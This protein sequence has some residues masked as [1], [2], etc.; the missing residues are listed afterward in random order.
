LHD[1]HGSWEK[2]AGTDGLQDPPPR[3]PLRTAGATAARL[4]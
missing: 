4:Q 3:W 2:P 1:A